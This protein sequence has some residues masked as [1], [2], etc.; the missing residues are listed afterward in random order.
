MRWNVS[1]EHVER[2][3]VCPGLEQE[4][5]VGAI[6]T[7]QF[8]AEPLRQSSLRIEQQATGPLVVRKHITEPVLQPRAL[9]KTA[10]EML[11]HRVVGEA[12][13]ELPEVQDGLIVAV[14]PL[15]QIV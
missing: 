9:R 14:Q 11:V 2:F 10:A 4:E 8:V 1:P 15:T 5:I 13:G 7:G 6:D 12:R 3:H